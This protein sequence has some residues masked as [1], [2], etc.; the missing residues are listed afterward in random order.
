MQKRKGHDLIAIHA[1]I[2]PSMITERAKSK[3]CTTLFTFSDG[4]SVCVHCKLKQNFLDFPILVQ[5]L[6]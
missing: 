5:T 4:F 6:F 1:H 3:L 2:F